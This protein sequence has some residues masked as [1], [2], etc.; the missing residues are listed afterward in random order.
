MEIQEN[1]LSYRVFLLQT[2]TDLHQV[3][4]GRLDQ[5]VPLF[6]IHPVGNKIEHQVSSNLSNAEG[7]KR[8]FLLQW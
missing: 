5:L 4:Q 8:K 3:Q 6:L 1:E 7:E 2:A